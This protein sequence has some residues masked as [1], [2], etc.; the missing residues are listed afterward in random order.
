MDH[1]IGDL[2][3]GGMGR[4]LGLEREA[5]WGGGTDVA[6]TRRHLPEHQ[7]AGVHV[8]AE[9]GVAREVNGALQ[10]L[11]S[12]VAPGPNLIEVRILK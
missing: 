4:G 6:A 9:E 7:A 12:H 5:V 2:L 10:H 1:Q 11:G 3:Q 8:D